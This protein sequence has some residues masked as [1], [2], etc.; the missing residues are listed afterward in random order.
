MYRSSVGS[1]NL[2]SLLK[3]KVADFLDQYLIEYV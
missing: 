3:E 1:T 2:I